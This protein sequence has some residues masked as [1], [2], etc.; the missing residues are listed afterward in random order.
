MR[1]LPKGWHGQGEVSRGQR[2]ESGLQNRAGAKICNSA[3]RFHFPR[4]FH[5]MIINST[6]CPWNACTV[7]SMA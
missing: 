7:S 6:I 2:P 5:S 1:F 3:N 4:A